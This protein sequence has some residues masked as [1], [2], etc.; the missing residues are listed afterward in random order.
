MVI[1]C[2]KQAKECLL[3]KTKKTS[4]FIDSPV[5]N[6]QVKCNAVGGG[7]LGLS[8]FPGKSITKVCSSTLLAL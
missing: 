1:V 6:I 8:D 4:F 5:R 2:L 3:H 7:G